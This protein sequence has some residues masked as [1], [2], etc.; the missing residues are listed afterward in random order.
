MPS[1]EES[2]QFLNESGKFRFSEDAYLRKIESITF[3]EDDCE[4]HLSGGIVYKPLEDEWVWDAVM[5]AKVGSYLIF[6]C[7]DV[8]VAPSSVESMIHA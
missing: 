1:I 3:M 8:L 4:F 6:G 7:G 2:M 5:D